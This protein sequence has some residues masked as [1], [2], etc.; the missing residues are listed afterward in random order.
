MYCDSVMQV[1][2]ADK[3]YFNAKK[4]IIGRMW[5]KIDTT[6]D[7]IIENI[8]PEDEITNGPDFNA[9]FQSMQQEYEQ[10]FIMFD[11]VT[12]QIYTA[13]ERLDKSSIKSQPL[14]L[15]DNLVIHTNNSSNIKL[16]PIEIQPFSGDYSKWITFKSMFDSLVH[17]NKEFSNVQKMHY[18]KSSLNGEAE[19][20]I[21]QFDITEN[22]YKPAYDLLTGRFHN[23]IIL[24]DNH[25]ANILAQPNLTS[26]TGEDIKELLDVTT[27]NL[28]ALKSLEVDTSTWDPLLLLLLVQKLDFDTRHLWEQQLK[29]KIRPTLKQFLDF[30]NTRFNALL[31]QRKFNFSIESLS[32]Q[33][34][35]NPNNHNTQY[36]SQQLCPICKGTHSI[37]SCDEFRQANQS[38]RVR[39]VSDAKLCEKCLRKHSSECTHQEGCRVCNRNHHTFLHIN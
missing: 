22:S 29:P 24:T 8:T 28:R 5:S 18:L 30:L 37:F 31:C 32:N 10:A 33:R 6:N 21:T 15:P 4:S 16:K 1:S 39:M 20:L 23:E 35:Q 17:N 36:S 9:T 38:D 19:R 3:G 25:I 7:Y 12:V 34:L 26:E 14:Q 27:E 13:I 11:K 2:E